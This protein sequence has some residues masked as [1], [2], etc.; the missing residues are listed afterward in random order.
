MSVGA[1]RRLVHRRVIDVI[2]YRL[3][4]RGS[5]NRTLDRPIGSLLGTEEKCKK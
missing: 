5:S 2:R 4:E 1:G 3:I